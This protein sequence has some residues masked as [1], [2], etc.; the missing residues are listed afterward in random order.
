MWVSGWCKIFDKRVV[1]Q[2]VKHNTLQLEAFRIHIT[3]RETRIDL[4]STSH[5]DI[6][7]ESDLP[8]L[9]RASGPEVA[10][11]RMGFFLP[12]AVYNNGVIESYTGISN[13]TIARCRW[14]LMDDPSWSACQASQK[15]FWGTPKGLPTSMPL[16]RYG[17]HS[18]A[19]SLAS[20]ALGPVRTSRASSHVSEAYEHGTWI[21]TG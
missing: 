19:H 6:S 20:N 9:I 3:F 11:E 16:R 7:L 18:T 17:W 12:L 21:L 5:F 4:W 2:F 13:G 1:L 15:H 8:E 10:C 14:S